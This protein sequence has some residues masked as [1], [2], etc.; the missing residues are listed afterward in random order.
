MYSALNCAYA[1]SSALGFDGNVGARHL[2]ALLLFKLKS[3]E[4]QIETGVQYL[5]GFF[6]L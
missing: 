2:F 6:V 4:S 1:L 3:S 5:I